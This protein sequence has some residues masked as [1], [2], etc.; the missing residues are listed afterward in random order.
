M[1]SSPNAPLMHRLRKACVISF[2]VAVISAAELRGAEPVRIDAV[3]TRYCVGCHDA[4]AN[5][6]GLNL[7]A[8]LPDD[9]AKHPETWEKVIH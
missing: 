7:A 5:K 6:A 2:A 1:Q 8:V 4:D 9:T 3:V